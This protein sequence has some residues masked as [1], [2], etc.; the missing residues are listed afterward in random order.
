MYGEIWVYLETAKEEILKVSLESLGAGR[1]LAET[2]GKPLCAVLSGSRVGLLAG[3]P[4]RYGADKV[5]LVE[6]N[7]ISEYDID[8]RLDILQ[9]MVRE[10]QPYLILF[11]TTPM[12]R[13]I[14]P[15]L[16]ARFQGGLVTEC[17][18][19]KLENERLT[20]RRPLYGG[21]AQATVEIQP[22]SL[23]ILTVASGVFE[24][25]KPVAGRTAEICKLNLNPQKS[26][27]VE[28]LKYI[29]GD[30]ATLSLTEAEIIIAVGKGLESSDRLPMIQELAG[31]LG[32]TLGG[33]RVAVDLKWM[34]SERQIGMT[35]KT[36]SPRLFIS[37]GISGQYPHTV[38]M[39][40]SENIIVINR[41]REAPMFKLASLGIVGSLEE[42][43]PVLS[44]RIRELLSVRKEG[45]N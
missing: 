37:C 26:S 6:N 10:Y 28:F 29:P 23:R 36:V 21:K 9:Q 22:C 14:A 15:R 7:E 5:Y 42:I 25:D 4:A 13:E 16:A 8:S 39:D 2:A 32:A 18:E 34:N 31:L 41:D 20:A 35:G 30:P 24:I 43:V 38:G 19:L 45:V 17:V 11:G 12:S 44:R 27:R 1:K 40:A 33:T 3:E